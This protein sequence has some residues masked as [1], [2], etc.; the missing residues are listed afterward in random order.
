MLMR[1]LCNLLFV[2]AGLFTAPCGA[3]DQKLIDEMKRADPAGGP[4]QLRPKF[5]TDGS[6]DTADPTAPIPIALPDG[7][8]IWMMI[9]SGGT[10]IYGD[11]LEAFLKGGMHQLHDDIDFLYEDGTKVTTK[12]YRINA[13]PWDPDLAFFKSQV[14]GYAGMMEMCNDRIEPT[15]AKDN[16]TRSRHAFHVEFAPVNASG[17]IHQVWKDLGSVQGYRPCEQTGTPWLGPVHAHG[18]GSH[19]IEDPSGKPFM[20]FDEVT[21]QRVVNG[22]PVPYRTEIIL[23]Q[24]DESRTRAIG[25]KEFALKVTHFDE[26]ERTYRAVRRSI[27]GFLIEGPHVIEANVGGVPY[28]LMFF[29]SGD[30][31]TDQYGSFYAY[32]P[33]AQGLTGP[34]TAAVD[35]S[36]ELVNITAT[37]TNEIDGTWGIGR[38]NPF[39]DS[40]GNLWIAA[41]VILKGDIPDNE[42]KSGWPPTYEELVKRARRALLI[43]ITLELRD[44]KPVVKTRDLERK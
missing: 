18:Y 29:S 20:F 3:V 32:R 25:P 34:F 14:V 42:T 7:R 40:Q 31:F 30:A 33:K 12:P 8:K 2:A 17:G 43:P 26:P 36:G 11:S 37:L 10:V 21:E 5:L 9:F 1:I 39:A 35:K 38:P 24:L 27:G 4:V 19:Y 44:G 6:Y 16:W 28:Y 41:H 22:F 23:R 15:R 13:A